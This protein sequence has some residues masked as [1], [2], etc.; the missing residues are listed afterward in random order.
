[1]KTLYESLLSDFDT[2]A[3]QVDP[4]KDIEE[5][6]KFHVDEYKKLVISKTPNRDG[7]YEVSSRGNVTFYGRSNSNPTGLTNGLFI[8]TKVKGNF[9]C[10]W[11][12]SLES[13]ESGPY[14]VGGSFNCSRCGKLITLE[15]APKTIGGSFK[16]DWCKSL[17]S[18]KGVPKKIP[19]DFDC[20]YCESLRTLKDGP[21]EVAENFFCVICGKVFTK[22]EVFNNTDVG[23]RTAV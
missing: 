15:G 9:D 5:F 10:S 3:N 22:Q 4:R 6:L 7:I 12:D 21:E 14:E 20:S 1:M 13:L 2:L 18:L 23:G 8:W 16:C 11:I 19:G 17:L